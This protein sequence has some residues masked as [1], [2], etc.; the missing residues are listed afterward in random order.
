MKI[1]RGYNLQE[2]NTKEIFLPIDFPFGL[3]INR[4]NETS[5]IEKKTLKLFLLNSAKDFIYLFTVI[6]P[7]IRLYV[8]TASGHFLPFYSFI[9][10]I[11][12]YHLPSLYLRVFIF[13][14]IILFATLPQEKAHTIFSQFL[15]YTST[16][17]FFY[18]FA[19]YLPLSHTEIVRLML[20]YFYKKRF[21]F[22]APMTQPRGSCDQRASRAWH[23][24]VKRAT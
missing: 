20:C 16:F 19:F 18:H 21:F 4:K 8:W 22:F 9:S 24:V 6:T 14:I 12:F 1:S 2:R 17:I 10:H 3:V 13:F 5:H 15:S 11:S 7:N 23:T